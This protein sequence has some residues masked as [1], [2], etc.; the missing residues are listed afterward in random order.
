MTEPNEDLLR[1][2]EYDGI[3]EYDNPTPRWW[4]AIFFGTFLFSIWYFLFF[5]TSTMS[6]SVETGYQ[7]AVSADVKKRFAEI[8]E[9]TADEETMLRLLASKDSLT[10]GATVFK[11]HCVSCHGPE[12]AGLVGPNLTDDYYKNVRS[13]ADIAAVVENGAA[14]GAMPAWKNRLHPNEVVLV[15]TYAAS[16]RGKDLPSS[17]GAEGESIPPWPA[18]PGTGSS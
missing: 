5:H 16:L 12:G 8:G 15:A 1:D 2:H 6:T 13:I 17:R 11:T 9:L 3:R 7:E 10:V 4:S 18:G 14:N